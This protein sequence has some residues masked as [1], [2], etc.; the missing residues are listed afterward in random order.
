VL[1]RRAV[2]GHGGGRL[3]L[4]GPAWIYEGALSFV[5]DISCHH[6]DSPYK[7][8]RGGPMAGGPRLSR[9]DELREAHAAQHHAHLGGRGRHCH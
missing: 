4:R 7:G 5:T 9:P 8:D 3:R 6:G 1:G 2:R